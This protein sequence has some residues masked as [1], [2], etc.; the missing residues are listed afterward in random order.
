M[1]TLIINGISAR[2][3]GGQTNLINLMNYLNKF[4]QKVIFILNSSNIENFSQYKSKRITLYEAR[5]AS[6]SILHRI[7]WEWFFLPLLLKKWSADIYYAP[8]GILTSRAPNCCK[9]I[10]TLQNMLPFDIIGRSKFPLFSLIRLKF[11]IL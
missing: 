5:F 9:S 8:G 10:T 4:N 2:R 6:F 3:G 7:L 11:F 1:K